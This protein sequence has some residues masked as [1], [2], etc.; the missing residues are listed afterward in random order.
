MLTN[1]LLGVEGY[2]IDCTLVSG[3]A[4]LNPLCER[5]PNVNVTISRAC[6][7]VLAVW[8]PRY[9]MKILLKVVLHT[10]KHESNMAWGDQHMLS[11]WFG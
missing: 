9:P 10:C 1:G 4:I 2:V 8:G 5:V 6:S 11:I 7:H 3:Q